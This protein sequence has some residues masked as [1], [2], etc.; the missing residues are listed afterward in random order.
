MT[1]RLGK[2]LRHRAA[3]VALTAVA[4]FGVS[5]GS[6]AAPVDVPADPA[7]IG[8]IGLCGVDGKPVT[9]GS[10]YEQPFV[11]TAISSVPAPAELQGKGQV[12]VLYAYQP[13]PGVPADQW[14]GDTLT[15]ASVYSTT[16]AP[17]TQ[18]T[19]LD[20]RLKDF[21]DNFPTLVDGLY[22][23]RMYFGRPGVA[24]DS[25]RY[26]ET[27]I[28]VSGDRWS[29]AKG[30]AVQCS[31]GKAV[32]NE[33]GS[34][35]TKAAGKPSPSVPGPRPGE[36]PVPGG[37]A[38]GSPGAGDHPSGVVSSTGGGLGTAT[39]E[40]TGSAPT[41]GTPGLSATATT[42]TSG[43]AEPSRTEGSGDVD[44]A[45][46]RRSGDDGGTGAVWWIV[47]GVAVAAA[48]AGSGVWLRRRA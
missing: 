22:E 15:A 7:A 3:L 43:P 2:S 46:A 44:P 6:A 11:W 37:S 38:A 14:S 29:V 48:A 35:G 28:Q 17:T 34:L 42:S 36:A 26:P 9:G 40:P 25:S 16:Q 4:V 24:L 45:A 18:A 12:A 19:R 33:I 47:G 41:S 39:A 31:A 10:V 5:H 20:F 27:F 21:M 32:S 1:D 30:G 13:R 23:L 8:Y